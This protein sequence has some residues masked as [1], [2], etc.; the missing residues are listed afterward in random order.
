MA[1]RLRWVFVL[2]NCLDSPTMKVPMRSACVVVALTVPCAVALAA[3]EDELNYPSEWSQTDIEFRKTVKLE[4]Y[5][6]G[7]Q[8]GAIAAW[9][10]VL[11]ID[12]ISPEQRLFA[13]W[14]IASRC[15]YQLD[16]RRGE[17]PDMAKAER[18]FKKARD[19]IPGRVSME[20]INAATQHASMWGTEIERARRKVDNYRWFRTRT[21][22]MVEDSVDRVSYS[23][24]VVGEEFLSETMHSPQVS[25]DKR[26]KELRLQL[27]QGEEC[28]V[29]QISEFIEWSNDGW[30]VKGLLSAVEDIADPV[31]LKTWRNTTSKFE[32]EWD[33]DAPIGDLNSEAV[34]T[35][36][37]T[38]R[39][40]AGGVFDVTNDAESPPAGAG[41]VRVSGEQN[42]NGVGE[43]GIPWVV[44]SFFAVVSV[45]LCVG[46]LALRTRKR[47][48]GLPPEK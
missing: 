32:Q 46:V 39:R 24:R 8:A 5:E 17:K 40:N 15:A 11:D 42:V 35:V 38:E 29:R 22:E 34:P 13:T 27:A 28:L 47:I 41:N 21:E 25:V 10:R 48:G 4:W 6:A 7:T 16:E 9:E 36:D 18:L 45:V 1:I 3:D 23:G 31:H 44:L 12:G 33:V 30:A 14:R 43:K 19:M 37:E 26:R 2:A 20:A